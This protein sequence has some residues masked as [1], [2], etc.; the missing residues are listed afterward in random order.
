MMTKPIPKLTLNPTGKQAQTRAR[1]PNRTSWRTRTANW[2][3]AAFLVAITGCAIP[4][5][6]DITAGWTVEQLYQEARDE[7]ESGRYADAIKLL[8][9]LESRYPFGRYAQQAQI[10]IA[11]GHY[12]DNERGLSLAAI[13][14]FIKL[15][16]NH[17]QLDYV[18]Y[19]KGL[20]NFN[21]RDSFLENLGG[22]DLSERDLQAAR[23]SFDAF[24]TVVTRFPTSKYVPD[25]QQRMRYL[26]NSMAAG[27]VSVAR[28]YFQ[29]NAFVAA[30]N[31]AQEVVR[32]Y[33]TVPAVEEALYIMTQSYQALGLDDLSE[34]AR[35]VLE[36]NFPDSK[37]L[38]TGIAQ[39]NTGW[40]QVWK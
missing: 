18:N 5:E 1:R 37:I 11:W 4:E 21:Q 26:V 32:E 34:A 39:Q 14:R 8:E 33:Q 20:V 9:I 16:P 13:D 29:H 10:D 25:A 30:A 7:M 35:R 22:Q 27:E 28:F 15:H 23:E 2:F 40:W 6:A 17:P 24:K 31:R 12:K 19:L 36:R 38:T 3:A